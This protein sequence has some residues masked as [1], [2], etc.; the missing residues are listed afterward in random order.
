MR[1]RRDRLRRPLVDDLVA[2]ARARRRGAGVR[3]KFEQPLRFLDFADLVFREQFRQHA[4]V[5]GGRVVGF[6]RV[7]GRRSV[8]GFAVFV[9]GELEFEGGHLGGWVCVV[10]GV[11]EV[12]V[13]LGVCRV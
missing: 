3:A 12:A 13:G 11:C 5:E 8:D 2:H 7:G 9:A 1:A 6:P 4:G 10:V